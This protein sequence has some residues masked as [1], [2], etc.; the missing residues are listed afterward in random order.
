MH[1]L[2]ILFFSLLFLSGY[3]YSVYPV[4]V[5]S[6]SRLF[7]NPWNTKEIMPAVSIIISVYNEERLIEEKIRNAL[8]LEYPKG[9]LEIIVSSDGSDDR[10]NE[11]VSGHKDSG[12]IL[13]AFTER[14]G[15]T[16]CLNRV[17]PLAKGEIIF[18]TD[19]NS[20]FPPDTVATMVR[21]FWDGQVG[22]VTGWTKYGQLRGGEGTTGVYTRLETVTK[23]WESLISSCVGADGAIFAMR[24]CLYKP[25]FNEDINDFVIPLHV[26]SQNHRVVLDPKVFC[27]EE[28]AE[29]PQKEFQRQVRM[30]NRTLSAIRRNPKFLNPFQPHFF[31]FFLLSH[32]VLRFLVPF[33]LLGTFLTNL[34]ILGLSPF[35]VIFLAAQIFTIVFV[36]AALIFRIEGRLLH[37]CKIFFIILSAQIVG[38]KRMISG[39]SDVIWTPQRKVSQ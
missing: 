21:N 38:W 2:E 11:I 39:Q 15:K 36:L 31:G 28:P 5:F 7:G 26:I 17:V 34:L 18:F 16:E 12:I 19:S 3:S 14:C 27:L 24:K 6:L 4:I 1:F 35:Y 23:F 37:F 29:S 10:T 32:K 20:V 25:L 33:F 22:L 30:T 13:Y 9:L 8:S